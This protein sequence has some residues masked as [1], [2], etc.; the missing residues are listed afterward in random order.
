MHRPPPRAHAASQQAHL[1]QRRL[2][3]PHLRHR[4]LV[5]HRV[6][7]KRRRS[8]EVKNL[9]PVAR[10]RKSRLP[11]V[12]HHPRAR[13]RP[14]RLTQVRFRMHAVRARLL[15]DVRAVRL[16]ARNHPIARFTRRH[17]LADGFH[18]PRRL[19]SQDARK[20]PLRVVSAE[21]F[22]ASASV[23]DDRRR[24]RVE[25]ARAR[26]RDSRDAR[27]PCTHPCDTARCTRF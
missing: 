13:V 27:A 24:V 7:G 16:I 6:L 8:H 19:V 14:H 25:S 4:H 11:V 23:R 3:V 12:L 10:E 21:L 20:L 5:H 26:A 18:R 15:R 17:A 9:R 1:I 22:D 2:V